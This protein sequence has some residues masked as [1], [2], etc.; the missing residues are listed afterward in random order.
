MEKLIINGG[1]RLEGRVKISGAKNAVLPIIAATLLGQEKASV[2]D[3]VP[4]LED[5]HT[6]TEVIKKLGV[7]ASFDE[8]KHQ[9]SVDSTQIDCC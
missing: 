3:D 9:L 1:H 6:I 8:E 2:L 4:A 7:K 5:V